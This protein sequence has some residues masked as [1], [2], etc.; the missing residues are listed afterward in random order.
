MYRVFLIA[1]NYAYQFFYNPSKMSAKLQTPEYTVERFPI[2]G[3]IIINNEKLEAESVTYEGTL[4]ISEKQNLINFSKILGKSKINYLLDHNGKIYSGVVTDISFSEEKPSTIS[5]SFTFLKEKEVFA[6]NQYIEGF[7]EFKPYIVDPT[8]EQ[9]TVVG[10]QIT[11]TAPRGI[12]MTSFLANI[13]QN[14]STVRIVDINGN[15][16]T[17]TA[18][19]SDN[20]LVYESSIPFKSVI[21]SSTSAMTLYKYSAKII[22]ESQSFVGIDF[23]SNSFLIVADGSSNIKGFTTSG[24]ITKTSNGI[25]GSSFSLTSTFLTTPGAKHYLFIKRSPT[26]SLTITVG[27]Q[28]YTMTS[29][30]LEFT[31]TTASPITIAVNQ[32]TTIHQVKLS[33]Y[34]NSWINYRFNA[35]DYGIFIPSAKQVATAIYAFNYTLSNPADN[36]VYLS[37]TKP[38]FILLGNSSVTSTFPYNSRRLLSTNYTNVGTVEF[39][40][41]Y[42]RSLSETGVYKVFGLFFTTASSTVYVRIDNTEF[43]KN[44]TDTNKVLCYELGDIIFT[45]KTPATISVRASTTSAYIIGLILLKPTYLKV[46]TN[47]IQSIMVYRNRALINRQVYPLSEVLDDAKTVYVAVFPL[48]VIADA[49]RTAYFVV[50]PIPLM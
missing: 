18:T 5:Y 16:Q 23:C 22:S 41:Q 38:A 17:I 14:P 48:G 40:G 26:V 12:L 8:P 3:S 31:P 34:K 35:F 9:D 50:Q 44:I 43:F 30:Y 27:S 39:T 32:S 7:F 45:S 28:Q 13:S 21:L 37:N 24:T 19:Y 20:A 49:L 2:I 47:T 29:E 25:S 1:D 15:V 10:S 4:P 11:I 36:V 46:N 6:L 33:T 42:I